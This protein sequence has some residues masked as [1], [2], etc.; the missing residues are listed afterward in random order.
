M[1]M[2]KVE[3]KHDPRQA[4]KFEAKFKMMLFKFYFILLTKVQEKYPNSLRLKFL[5]VT[6][7]K[8]D[9]NNEF[10]ALFL[11]LKT[12]GEKPPLEW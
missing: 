3:N 2:S 8:D 9:M 5:A 4:K 1:D 6:C 10:K 11:I 12:I 7:L